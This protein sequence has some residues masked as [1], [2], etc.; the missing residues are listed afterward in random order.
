MRLTLCQNDI[1]DT[2]S[3]LCE[4]GGHISVVQSHDC[5]LQVPLDDIITLILLLHIIELMKS[6]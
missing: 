6:S 1:S 4:V 3:G 5:S 2:W